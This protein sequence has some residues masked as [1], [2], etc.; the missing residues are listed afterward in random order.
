MHPHPPNDPVPPAGAP[1]AE[2]VRL[3][4]PI[5]SFEPA[6]ARLVGRAVAGSVAAAIGLALLALVI[7]AAWRQWSDMPWDSAHG[8]NRSA[9]L[10][11][12]TTGLVALASGAGVVV[13]AR[14]DLA[15]RV[16]VCR[17]GCYRVRPVKWR[18]CHW[19]QIER[20]RFYY[21]WPPRKGI[22]DADVPPGSK[23]CSVVRMEVL[24]RGGRQVDFTRATVRDLT[25]L[26]V[27]LKDEADRRGTPWEVYRPSSRPCCG[28]NHPPPPAP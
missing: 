21:P 13:W 26:A 6:R 25:G 22:P 3:G 12:G 16:Y 24:L 1:E 4:E 18:V 15:S 11:L 14:R 8:W 28:N 5:A 9:I 20:L 23:G 27:M 7:P 19:D 10:G 2:V 17:D